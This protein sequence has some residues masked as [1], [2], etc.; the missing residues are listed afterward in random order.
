MAGDKLSARE[1][2]LIAQVRAELGGAPAAPQNAQAG[3]QPGRANRAPPPK[4][5]AAAAPLSVEPAV[6]AGETTT[7]DPAK[8][9][10]ALIAAARAE[11]EQLRRR[12]RRRY[13]WAPLAFMCVLGLWALLWMWQKL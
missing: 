10:A 11:S 12:Q 9:V 8:R 5:P 3:A 4:R 6:Q 7:A 1:A 2:A 13:V